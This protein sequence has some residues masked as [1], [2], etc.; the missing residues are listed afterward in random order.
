MTSFIMASKQKN[1][2]VMRHDPFTKQTATTTT[3]R[4]RFFPLYFLSD[5]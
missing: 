2:I 3:I 4:K 5:V 1:F